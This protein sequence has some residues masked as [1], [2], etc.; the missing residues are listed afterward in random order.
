[1]PRTAAE[2][3]TW[4]APV[5]PLADIRAQEANRIAALAREE[6]IARLRAEYLQLR[7]SAWR[8]VEYWHVV[9]VL[10]TLGVEIPD[11]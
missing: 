5:D 1:M 8:S 3:K 10:R 6:K 11:A 4:D 9:G 2:K 7:L